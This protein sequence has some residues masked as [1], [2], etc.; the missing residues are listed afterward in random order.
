MGAN[1]FSRFVSSNA[2]V[3]GVILGQF[4]SLI[5]VLFVSPFFLLLFSLIFLF[6]FVS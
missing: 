3:M 4:V 1:E 2:L 5:S 6:L